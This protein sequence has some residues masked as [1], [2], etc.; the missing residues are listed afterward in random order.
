MAYLQLRFHIRR[1]RA[2]NLN[3]ILESL[4]ALSVTWENAGED[5]YFEI[6]WPRE[7]DWRYL[8]VTG[9]FDETCRPDSVARQVNDRL[10]EQLIPQ[11]KTLADQDWERAWLTG[12]APR[13]YR[14]GLWVCPSWAE[15][16]DPRAVNLVIDPGLA[17]GTGD[18]ATTALCLDWISERDLSGLTVMDY[19]CGSGILA[20]AGLLKGAARAT[21]VD[22]D[23][24]AVSTSRLNASR[25]GVADRFESCL[26]DAL[27]PGRDFDLV[28]ANILSNVLIEHSAALARATRA[29][30]TLLLTGILEDHAGKVKAAFEPAF[31]F[32]AQLRDGWCLLIGEKRRPSR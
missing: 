3:D 1:E 16:P 5:A 21:G 15:P 6:A 29:G 12:F 28:M 7:P 10:G 31:T 32:Q 20:I 22:V 11:L 23:P 9:L 18:H 8:Y 26:P 30:G 27:P 2:D 24:R 13:K 25:N 14:G 19:G 4:G 17:F